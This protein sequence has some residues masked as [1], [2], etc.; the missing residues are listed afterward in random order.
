MASGALLWVALAIATPEAPT[1]VVVTLPGVPAPAIATA[2]WAGW[3][4]VPMI[5]SARPAPAP[6]EGEL[7]ALRRLW[8]D[9]DFARCLA[10]ARSL[11]LDELLTARHR[12]A[13][14]EQIALEAGCALGAGDEPLAQA[15]LRRAAVA[16]LD[17]TG[18]LSRMTTD[19]QRA[20]TSVAAAV[21]KS[22]LHR[23]A[24]ST[25]PSPATVS[26]DGDGTACPSTPCE[27]SLRPGRHVLAAQRLGSLE[28]RLTVDL[29]APTARRI[30][31]DPAPAQA[32]RTQ[33]AHALAT[34]PPDDPRLA[35]LASA[36]FAARLTVLVWRTPEGLR[37]QLFDVRATDGPR[38]MARA[39]G[40]TVDAVLSSLRSIWQDEQ[41]RTL[42]EEPMF[43]VGAVAVV[44]AVVAG[45]YLLTREP[46]P[47]LSLVG[48]RPR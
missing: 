6:P 4:H 3:Q 16:G 2:E 44:G 32:L 33:L 1:G 36:A 26:I 5:P 22:S 20:W 39:R 12:A 18:P 21:A 35:R 31:L 17:L 27:V 8:E 10:A 37:G 30:A 23:V 14:A 43:W 25:E 34:H 47:T 42:L 7:A 45:T 40:D 28:R 38:V 29:T 48:A 11:D 15:L 46:E 24:L 13:A 19:L 9:A 41:P